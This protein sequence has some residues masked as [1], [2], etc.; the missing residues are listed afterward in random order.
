MNDIMEIC[1]ITALFGAL[2]LLVIV[3]NKRMANDRP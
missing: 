1:M 2:Y 3:Y